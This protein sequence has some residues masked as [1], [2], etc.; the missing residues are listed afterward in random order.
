[1]RG[2]RNLA[3]ILAASLFLWMGAEGSSPGDWEPFKL[4]RQDATFLSEVLRDGLMQMEMG[5]L[6]RKNTANQEVAKFAES[7]IVDYMKASQELV[8]LAEGKTTDIP[9]Q[10]DS[11]RQDKADEIAW[12][13]GEAFDRKYIDAVIQ[14]LHEVIGIYRTE[15][16]KGGVS[17]FKSFAAGRASALEDHL[18]EAMQLRKEG[19]KGG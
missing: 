12:L 8:R 14:E 11:E 16:E 5:G 7:M 13:S 17:P 18:R 15:A 10:I 1:M 4:G 9:K 19:G 6:A 3:F 2:I